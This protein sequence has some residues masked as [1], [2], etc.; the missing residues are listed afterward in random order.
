[1]KIL[2]SDEDAEKLFSKLCVKLGFCLAEHHRTRIKQ[3]ARTDEGFAQAVYRAEG[4]DPYLRSELYKSVLK[5]V[6]AVFRCYSP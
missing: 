4:L 1:M 5:E 3:V 2:L 6:S